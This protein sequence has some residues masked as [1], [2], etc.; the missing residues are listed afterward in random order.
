MFLCTDGIRKFSKRGLGY[1]IVYFNICISPNDFLSRNRLI[2]VK[3]TA[4]NGF[5]SHCELC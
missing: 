1:F 2:S 5:R 4:N 3:E